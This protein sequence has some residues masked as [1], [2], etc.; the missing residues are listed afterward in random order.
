V[1]RIFG[2]ARELLEVLAATD[3]AAVIVDGHC[4]V[5]LAPVLPSRRGS[6]RN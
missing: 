6:I 1:L 2:E 4:G 3:L 5:D